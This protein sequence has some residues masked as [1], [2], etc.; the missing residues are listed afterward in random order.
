MNDSRINRDEL[1]IVSGIALFLY[2]IMRNGVQGAANAATQ[3][4]VNAASGAVTGTVDATGQII[5][6]PPLDEI[7]TDK[8]VSRY[9]IDHPDGG[10][11]AASK[12]SSAAAFAAALALDQYSGHLPSD[13]SAILQAFP[14]AANTGSITGSW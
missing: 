8:Y 13:G 11:F 7:T 6:L 1:I 14:P 5:G 4:I 12:W 10:F 9:I 2:L 3:A